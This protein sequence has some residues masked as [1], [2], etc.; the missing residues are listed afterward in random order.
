MRVRDRLQDWDVRHVRE[1][2]KAVAWHAD[3]DPV[4]GAQDWL[5]A[6]EREENFTKRG[7]CG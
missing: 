6:E 2:H 1:R 7:P 4:R 3:G 5:E